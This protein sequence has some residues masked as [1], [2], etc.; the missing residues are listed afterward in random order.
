MLHNVNQLLLRHGTRLAAKKMMNNVIEARIIKRKYKGEG[1][2][3]PRTLMI[4]TDLPF[5]FKRLQ[6]SV[7]LAFAMT[8]NKSQGQSLEVCE[9]NLE[10]PCFA[11]GQLFD[12]FYQKALN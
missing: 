5:D 10:F 12:A 6:F 1:V 9:I 11:H 7:R 8:I 3:I 2:L 4:T